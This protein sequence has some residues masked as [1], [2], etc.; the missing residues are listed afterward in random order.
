[1]VWRD[2]ARDVGLFTSLGWVW[3]ECFLGFSVREAVPS[4]STRHK[5]RGDRNNLETVE[6]EEEAIV[7]YILRISH[8]PINAVLIPSVR[9][10]CAAREII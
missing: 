4:E 1:M 9:I 2:I 5:G 10:R 7:T 8:K 3:P 6:K